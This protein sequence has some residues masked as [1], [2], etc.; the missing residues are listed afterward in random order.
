MEITY[1]QNVLFVKIPNLSVKN[2]LR[3][4]LKQYFQIF[5]WSD[6]HVA[7]KLST[8]SLDVFAHIVAYLLATFEMLLVEAWVYSS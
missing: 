1:S 3:S 6:L 2:V 4:F 5:S 8:I 7:A